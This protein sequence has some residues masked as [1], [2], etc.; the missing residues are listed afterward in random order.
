M[1]NLSQMGMDGTDAVASLKIY[2][3]IG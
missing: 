3:K 1:V 2:A